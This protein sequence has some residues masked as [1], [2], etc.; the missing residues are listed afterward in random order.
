[1]ETCNACTEK[2]ENLKSRNIK[3]TKIETVFKEKCKE[4]FENEEILKQKVEKLTLECQDFEKENDILKQKC[5]A[6][7]NEC[8]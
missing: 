2:D 8:S 1:M 4:R 5:S 7:C 6:N 3:F